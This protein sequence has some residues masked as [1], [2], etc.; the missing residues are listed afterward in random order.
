MK[1]MALTVIF[2]MTLMPV[3]A[4]A[5]VLTC[6]G[7]DY[8]T[9]CGTVA[10]AY[11][12][13]GYSNTF[14]GS[15]AGYSNTTGTN[16]TF[17]GRLA[18]S[19]SNGYE[20]IFIGHEAGYNSDSGENISI[21]HGA[22]FANTSGYGNVCIGS[23]AGRAN[24][25]GDSNVFLGYSAG[26]SE[27][28]SNKLYIDNCSIKGGPP[29]YSCDYPLIYGEFD[30]RIVKINGALMMT[31]VLTPSDIRLKKEIEPLKSSLERV[32]KLQ[33]VS[34]SWK[35]D[36]NPGRGFGPGRNIGLI[37]QDVEKVI[38]EVVYTDGNGIK[39]LSYDKLAPVL[40]EA[41][42]EQQKTIAEKSRIIDEQR[43]AIKVLA[44]RLAKLDKLEAEVNRLKSRD[45][46]VQ[47]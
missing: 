26:S 19:A 27:L 39:D 25:S 8:N 10:G 47:R 16:N 3:F 32:I 40:V 41:I 12:S 44:E 17:L 45:M 28:G 43:S 1:K 37:A 23:G 36:E 21:G 31:A 24:I 6:T 29:E 15:S 18:G 9:F 46:S 35:A 33:G 34:Y 14:I 38:P 4:G 11:N 42:K 30:N 7:D 5:A 22:G 20:N 13:S 2:I